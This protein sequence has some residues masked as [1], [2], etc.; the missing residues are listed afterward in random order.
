MNNRFWHA[1]AAGVIFSA[2]FFAPRVFRADGGREARR[3]CCAGEEIS[4]EA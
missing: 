2:L 4:V 1:C 3:D